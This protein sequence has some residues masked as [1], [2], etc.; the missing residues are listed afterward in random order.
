MRYLFFLPMLAALQGCWFIYIPAGMFRSDP[1]A[2]A[3]QPAPQ[4]QETTWERRGA[5]AAERD[6]DM[7]EC[8]LQLVPA[9]CMRQKGWQSRASR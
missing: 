3:A 8:E 5:S 2:V 7:R 1:D 9:A 4:T 6:A